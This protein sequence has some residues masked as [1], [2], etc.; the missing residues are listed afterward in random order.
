MTKVFKLIIIFSI[1]TL[2]CSKDEII[3]SNS[4]S[5]PVLSY[6][7]EISET[8]NLDKSRIIIDK[9]KQL[10]FWTQHFHN[11]G[12]DLN[13]ISTDAS[14]NNRSK[15]INGKRGPKNIIQP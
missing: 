15:I 4:N 9:P 11:P 7:A 5:F 12:N 1:L 6:N 8:L 14:F 3:T 2:S 10:N 13:N